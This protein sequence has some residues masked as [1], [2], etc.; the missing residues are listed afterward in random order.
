[1]KLYLSSYKIGD[2]KKFLTSFVQEVGPKMFYIPNALDFTTAD[3]E[4]RTKHIQSDIADL[5]ALGFQVEVLDLKDYFNEEVELK[6]KLSEVNSVW[7]SG[8]NTFVLRQAMKLS[9]F[10]NLMHDVLDLRE[11]FLYAGYSAGSCVLS[12]DLSHLQ[13]VDD[14]TDL[15]Y[16]G[17]KEA[18][19]DGLNILDFAIL[20]HYDSDHPESEAI[21]K[22]VQY[23]IDNK[24]LFIA[25][26][27]G[28][29]ILQD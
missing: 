27:D 16:E 5:S 22:E 13:I 28:E 4:R 11:D 7:V 20:P 1:M 3:P 10:D 21:G 17:V 18:I 6:K 2:K 15:P 9:G 8:G 12:S 25:L 24:I 14:A 19:M 26:R 29:V 23:C